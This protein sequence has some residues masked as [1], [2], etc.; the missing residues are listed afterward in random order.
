MFVDGHTT[1]IVRDFKR[2]VFINYNVEFFAVTRKRFIDAV[3][4]DFM[5]QVIWPRRIGVHAWPAPYR[6]QP[7][8][9]FDV[10]SVVSFAHVDRVLTREMPGGS[11]ALIEIDDE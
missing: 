6:L 3:V 1:A 4:D 10:R 7:T 8:K 11:L 9:D 2:A 5:G